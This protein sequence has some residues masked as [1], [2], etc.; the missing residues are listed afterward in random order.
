MT[1]EVTNS[2]EQTEERDSR[3]DKKGSQTVYGTHIYP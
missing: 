2:I 3:I 1:N